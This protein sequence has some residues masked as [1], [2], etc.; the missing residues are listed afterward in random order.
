MKKTNTN[1]T[2]NPRQISLFFVKLSDVSRPCVGKEFG[3]YGIGSGSEQI[4]IVVKNKICT[5]LTV[6]NGA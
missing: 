5:K 3:S 6:D 1:L 2:Y 4:K